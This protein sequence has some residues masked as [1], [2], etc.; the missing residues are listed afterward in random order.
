MLTTFLQSG[1]VF[2]G[3]LT[4]ADLST[5]NGHQTIEVQSCRDERCT[6]SQNEVLS[7]SLIVLNKCVPFGSK[8]T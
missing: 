3:S 4:M 1:E 8:H 7:K 6:T 2:V 5:A